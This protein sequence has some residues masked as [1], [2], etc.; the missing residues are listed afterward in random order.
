MSAEFACGRALEEGHGGLGVFGVSQSEEV[1]AV[2]L[3]LVASEQCK[4]AHQKPSEGSGV[5][6]MGG[7]PG[8]PSLSAWVW[9]KPRRSKIQARAP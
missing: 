8:R 3:E 2:A 4:P 5:R 1:R 7:S 9:Q 6:F